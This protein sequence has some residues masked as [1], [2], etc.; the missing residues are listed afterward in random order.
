ML[1][2]N[3]ALIFGMGFLN[4]PKATL[5]FGGDGATKEISPRARA[6]LDEL[7]AAGYCEVTTANDSIENREHYRGK[8]VDGTGLGVIAQKQGFDP[9]DRSNKWPSFTEIGAALPT[10][11]P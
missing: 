1:L 3:D 2:S 7:L 5:R 8:L 6:A 4:G 9:F 10:P 11:A